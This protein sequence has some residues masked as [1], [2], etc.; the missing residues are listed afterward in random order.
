[1]DWGVGQMMQLDSPELQKNLEE[2]QDR[3]CKTEFHKIMENDG[4][5]STF[6]WAVFS[7]NSTPLDNGLALEQFHILQLLHSGL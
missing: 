6:V 2:I 3:D 4:L 5:K 7:F 1:M